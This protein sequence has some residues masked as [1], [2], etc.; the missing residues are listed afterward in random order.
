MVD[1]IASGIEELQRA[2]LQIVHSE[3]MSSLGQLVAGIAHEINNPINFI[4]GN[5]SYVNDCAQ[6]LLNAIA[7]YHA[8]DT[9]S[10]TLTS[11]P[12]AQ[13]SSLPDAYDPPDPEELNFL[14]EDLPKVCAS[15]RVGAERVRDIVLSLRNFARLDE[16]EL[17]LV[18]IHDGL[19]NAVLLLGYRLE[20]TPTRSPITI[21]RD[22]GELPDLEC[23]P[24]QL[25]QAL[26]NLVLN[27]I[28]SF[29]LESD[30]PVMIKP[31][32]TLQTRQLDDHHISILIRDT[33]KGM[34]PE[35]QT[36]IFDPFFTTKPIG[37]NKGLGLSI[38]ERIITVQHGGTIRL[39]STAGNG[40]EVTITLP[41]QA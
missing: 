20:A 9:E 5:I 36:K 26:L 40:T 12:P 2:Q 17:K 15:M 23:Y 24:G 37:Q 27:A 10:A 33:G 29:D 41:I 16:A 21:E 25:N 31:Q 3:K 39:Q 18:N 14:I 30:K 11:N 35:L 34:T 1:Q 4:Y 28:E 8:Q 6:D 22:Y 13:T 38:A 32:I 7:Y 19:D